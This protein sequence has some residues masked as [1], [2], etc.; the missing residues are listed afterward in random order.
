MNCSKNL[1]H[2]FSAV[3]LFGLAVL[4]H[5][6]VSDADLQ[7]QYGDQVLTLRR[8]YPGKHLRFDAA[9][10]LDSAVAPGTWT[11]DGQVRVQTIS[12]KNGVIHIRGQRSFLFFDPE[13]KKLRALGSV[14]NTER[15]SKLFREKVGDWAAKEGKIE[16]AVESGMAHPE[17]ADLLN[18]MNKVFLAPGEALWQLELIPDSW[19]SYLSEPDLE[20]RERAN[21]LVLD[22][23]VSRVGKGVSPPRQTY[24]P[25]PDYSELAKQARY[26]G[27]ETVTLVVDEKGLPQHIQILVPAGLGLDEAAVDT[28]RTWRFDPATR[29]GKPIAV[30]IAVEVHFHLY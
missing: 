28:V 2:R 3:L 26:E 27:V 22:E 10:K 24:A 5:G 30:A 13:E 11:V 7:K 14:T 8:F 18:A 9:G 23:G 25:Q 4:A 16:I 1:H 17:M 12:L 15:I 19:K 29:D 21:R 6:S 20:P